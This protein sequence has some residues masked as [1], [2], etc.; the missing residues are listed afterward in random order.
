MT[1]FAIGA[2]VRFRST[3]RVSTNWWGVTGT[4][5]AHMTTGLTT[6]LLDKRRP[7]GRTDV[8]TGPWALELARPQ[9]KTT[10]SAWN[11]TET[12]KP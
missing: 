1:D 7:D 12:N 6:I 8:N 9:P 11:I 10:R 4:V 5:L 2:R 3:S